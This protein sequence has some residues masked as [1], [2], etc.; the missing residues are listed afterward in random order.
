MNIFHGSDWPQKI[1]MTTWF[2]DS[3]HE[4]AEFKNKEDFNKHLLNQ[5]TGFNEFVIDA[6]LARNQR[7]GT[8]R[9]PFRCPLCESTPSTIF[10]SL[11]NAE[12]TS[13]LLDHIGAHLLFFSLFSLPA[14]DHIPNKDEEES[15][16]LS[17]ESCNPEWNNTNI[18]SEEILSGET[19]M[20]LFPVI[21]EDSPSRLEKIPSANGE[22]VNWDS[23]DGHRRI[24]DNVDRVLGHLRETQQESMS[25][26]ELLTSSKTENDTED[27]STDEDTARHSLRDELK[28][29]SLGS[30]DQ[31]DSFIPLDK[32]NHLLT[33]TAIRQELKK[34]KIKGSKNRNMIANRILNGSL[35][36]LEASSRKI[37][38]VLCMMDSP[39]LILDFLDEGVF[40]NQLPFVFPENKGD[41]PD[42]PQPYGK[43]SRVPIRLFRREGGWEQGTRHQFDLYQ[44]RV[45]APYFQLRCQDDRVV[46]H[47]MVDDCA[48]LPFTEMKFVAEQGLSATYQIKIHVAHYNAHGFSVWNFNAAPEFYI[49]KLTTKSRA[50]TRDY[51]SL[52]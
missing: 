37:F 6:M 16:Q 22:D 13:R 11:T 46:E 43:R 41:L 2:C 34:A 27:D 49:R 33:S 50:Q 31:D 36:E 24:Q 12:K 39:E 28:V 10:Q 26:R 29:A 32:L 1:H 45:M 40:D 35:S 17:L 5:H 47:L 48:V 30:L 23:Y 38:A 25:L 4:L 3:G 7:E 42:F 14:E 8:P 52:H 15:K 20:R 18:R 51:R 44:W 9:D 19:A 21:E